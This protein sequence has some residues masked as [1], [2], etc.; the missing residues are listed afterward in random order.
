MK[1]ETEKQDNLILLSKLGLH[2]LFFF[3]PREITLKQKIR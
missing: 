3:D 2:I 1:I